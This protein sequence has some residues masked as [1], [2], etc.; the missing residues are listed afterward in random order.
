MGAINKMVDLSGIK[1][2]KELS[3]ILRDNTE[4]NVFTALS[5]RHL[6]NDFLINGM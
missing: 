3:V 5:D 2:F 6:E 1:V 4:L